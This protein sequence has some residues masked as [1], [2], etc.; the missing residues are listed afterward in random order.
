MSTSKETKDGW[1]CTLEGVSIY[2]PLENMVRSTGAEKVAAWF[3]D[4]DFDGRC[5][6]ITQAFFPDQN[7]WE[8][9]AKALGTSADMRGLR[10]A[11]GHVVAALS[12]G[13]VRPHSGRKSSILA[14]MK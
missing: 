6:C 4:S 8:K 11:Q 13:Q 7:A 1:V 2:D 10:E 12:E 14:A 9:I 3:L 5:F